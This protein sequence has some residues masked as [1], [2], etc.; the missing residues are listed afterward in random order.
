MNKVFLSLLL[1]VIGTAL[2][3][4]EAI[5]GNMYRSTDSNVCERRG[6]EQKDIQQ[7]CGEP[8]SL[9]AW[10][11]GSWQVDSRTTW[12]DYPTPLAP[13]PS[14]KFIEIQVREET[15]VI[16]EVSDYFLGQNYAKKSPYRVTGV[17]FS[18]NRLK[19]E[20]ENRQLGLRTQYS[21]TV[22]NEDLMEGEFAEISAGGFGLPGHQTKG[23]TTF[24]KQQP[25]NF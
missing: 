17:T 7:L 25:M 1:A 3:F 2:V 9:P 15:L 4:G 23:T 8:S 13:G 5:G 24:T 20:L 21:L 18:G 16:S 6:V 12:W 22:K 14:N 19:F 11:N 10:L